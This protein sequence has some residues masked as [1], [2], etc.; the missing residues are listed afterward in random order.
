MQPK[1]SIWFVFPAAVALLLC[2][3]STLV[4]AGDD[5]GGDNDQAAP[6]DAKGLRKVMVSSSVAISKLRITV[7]KYQRDDHLSDS[8]TQALLSDCMDLTEDSKEVLDDSMTILVKLHGAKNKSGN[9]S[10]SGSGSGAEEEEME[11]L[12]TNLSAALTDITTCTDG[13]HDEITDESAQTK[14]AVVRID[15][16]AAKVSELLSKALNLTASIDAKN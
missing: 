7:K 11:L 3:S 16:Q 4:A 1:I 8:K 10:S 5:G 6:P 12:R 13:L 14:K 9:E 15:R 2:S